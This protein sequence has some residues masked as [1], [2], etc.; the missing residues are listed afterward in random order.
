MQ[1]DHLVGGDGGGQRHTPGP[2]ELGGAPG[3]TPKSRDWYA[4]QHVFNQAPFE[5]VLEEE[6]AVY[7]PSGNAGPVCLVAGPENARLIAAAPELKEQL[8]IMTALLRIKCGNLELDVFAEIEKSEAVL[9][10][11]TGAA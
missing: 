1:K 6:W 5:G 4:V 10:K 7:P 3:S 9:A 11:A 2:W 8:A